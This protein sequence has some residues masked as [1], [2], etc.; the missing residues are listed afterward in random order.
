MVDI[1]SPLHVACSPISACVCVHVLAPAPVRA[2]VRAC[3]S[4]HLVSSHCISRA[5]PRPSFIV[6]YRPISQA[7]LAFIPDLVSQSTADAERGDIVCYARLSAMSIVHELAN[8]RFP[9]P[10]APR[11]SSAQRPCGGPHLASPAASWRGGERSAECRRAFG[12]SG[13]LSEEEAGC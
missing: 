11:L 10:P 3:L 1:V 9:A 2:C 6:D 13:R 8:R 12:R 7:R 4:C 5:P